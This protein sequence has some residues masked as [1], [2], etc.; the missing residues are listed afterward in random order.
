M[1][2]LLAS[3]KEE[4]RKQQLPDHPPVVETPTVAKASA[5]AEVERLHADLNERFIRGID[6]F[7]ATGSMAISV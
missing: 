1:E 3:A 6:E 2:K 5:Q 7:F 4:Y